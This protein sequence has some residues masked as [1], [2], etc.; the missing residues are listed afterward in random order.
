MITIV[1]EKGRCCWDKFPRVQVT[2]GFHPIKSQSF[3]RIRIHL[4][5]KVG[6]SSKRA[7]GASAGSNLRNKQTDFLMRS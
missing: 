7:K 6:G 5:L 3:R 4:E 1:T 2:S